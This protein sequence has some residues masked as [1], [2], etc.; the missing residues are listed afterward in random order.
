MTK[1]NYREIYLILN[2]LGSNYIKKVP[3]SVYTYIVQNMTT[4][5]IA[6]KTISKET[7][8]FIAGLHYRYWA[9]SQEEKQQ[10]IRIFNENQKIKDEK[11]NYENLFKNKDLKNDEN[12]K[13][14]ENEVQ[15]IKIEKWYVRIVNF[16]RKIFGMGDKHC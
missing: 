10:L 5:D 14:T 6:N 16:F 1:E 9:E 7:I 11:N 8:A 4:K 2:K 13:T 12:V 15:L 3:K